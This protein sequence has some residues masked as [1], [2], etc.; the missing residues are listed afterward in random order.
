MMATPSEVKAEGIT[1]IALP[2]PKGKSPG[3]SEHDSS[4]H[5]DFFVDQIPSELPSNKKPQQIKIFDDI[6]HA[7]NQL[8]HHHHTSIPH[9]SNSEEPKRINRLYDYLQGLESKLA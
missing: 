6:K 8:D 1:K 3:P 4:W 7:P 2:T 9:T 5:P